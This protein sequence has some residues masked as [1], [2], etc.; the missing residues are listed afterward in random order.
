MELVDPEDLQTNIHIHLEAEVIHL[1]QVD[2]GLHHQI[3]MA[4]LQVGTHQTHKLHMGTQVI[5]KHPQEVILP[6]QWPL[7]QTQ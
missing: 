3:I 4:H 7:P 6:M 5:P 1:H 2:H